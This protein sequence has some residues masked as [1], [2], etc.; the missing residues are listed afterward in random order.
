MLF[1]L[2]LSVS[3]TNQCIT[4]ILENSNRNTY[5]PATHYKEK[6]K[7]KPIKKNISM[8]QRGGREPE[9]DCGGV[10]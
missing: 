3:V 9:I 5:K 4:D 1:T 10:W 6:M 7:W 8:Q 2:L